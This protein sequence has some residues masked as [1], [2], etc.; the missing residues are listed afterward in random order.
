VPGFSSIEKDMNDEREAHSSNDEF[1]LCNFPLQGRPF[2]TQKGPYYGQNDSP[3]DN[4]RSS[5][6]EI[7]KSLKLPIIQRDYGRADGSDLNLRWRNT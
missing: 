2:S 6:Y 4:S 3:T 1:N 5:R 7:K